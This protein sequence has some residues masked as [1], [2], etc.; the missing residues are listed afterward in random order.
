VPHLRD[1][2]IVAKVG[3]RA[4]RDPRFLLSAV[5][6]ILRAAQNPGISLEAHHPLS[7]IRFRF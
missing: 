5:V 3:N 1:G 2:F 6:V 7:T 4:K